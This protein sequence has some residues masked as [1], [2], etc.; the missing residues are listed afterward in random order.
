[1][2]AVYSLEHASPAAGADVRWETGGRPEGS[3]AR[4]LE[5]EMKRAILDVA[6]LVV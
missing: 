1:M 3:L 6:G 4:S 2:V 5:G